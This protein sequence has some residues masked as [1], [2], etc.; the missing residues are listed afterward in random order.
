MAFPD[1]RLKSLLNKEDP[2]GM[3]NQKPPHVLIL[4]DDFGRQKD[5]AILR[6]VQKYRGKSM[7]IIALF[8]D[9]DSLA[10][11]AHLCDAA[12]TPP[13]KTIDLR[14]IVVELCAKITGK[15][16]DL[17]SKFEDED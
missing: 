16:I 3:V 7:R 13:W 4:S 11:N 17:T 1:W 10:A 14:E 2:V 5:L 12:L 9:A 6:A 8:E 15:P